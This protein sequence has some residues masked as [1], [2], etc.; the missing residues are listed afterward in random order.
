VVNYTVD[1]INYKE[2]PNNVWIS[3]SQIETATVNL[4][5]IDVL[6]VNGL[7]YFNVEKAPVVKSEGQLLVGVNQVEVSAFRKDFSVDGEIPHLGTKEEFS[8]YQIFKT[9]TTVKTINERSSYTNR[10]FVSPDKGA[11]TGVIRGQSPLFQYQVVDEPYM[12]ACL[13]YM[14]GTVSDRI[15]QPNYTYKFSFQVY[16]EK[17]YVL[18]ICKAVFLQGMRL[19]TAKS[20][21]NSG[22][23]YGSFNIILNGVSICSSDK[24]YTVYTTELD[25][26]YIEDGTSGLGEQ[27]ISFSMFFKKGWNTIDI[28]SSCVNPSVYGIDPS[29]PSDYNPYLQLSL[30]PSLF[31]PRVKE[32][33]GIT[34]ILGS[35]ITSPVTEFDLLFNT[36]QDFKFWAWSESNNQVLFN[37][38][39]TKA[40]DGFFVGENPNC[41]IQYSGVSATD[42][43]LNQIGLKLNFTRDP[44]T[45][46]GPI[47]DSYSI[48]VR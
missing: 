36:P 5:T 37:T 15:L 10:L 47:A 4:K 22:K 44:E 12:D 14:A 26:S 19:R 41:S 17:D 28:I 7:Y 16:S 42:I 1:G 29:N 38:W 39:G 30:F 45:G 43:G 18:D 20:Y 11:T 23:S 31:D 2:I 25:G 33:L 35:Q 8:N 13:L 40:I 3:T 27:G 48:M 6:S 24:P 9:W 34:K 32:E 46:A 21:K